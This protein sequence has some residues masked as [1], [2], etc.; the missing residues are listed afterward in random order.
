M[1]NDSINQTLSRTVL[2]S[3]HTLL[4]LLALFILGGKVLHG[5]AFALLAGIMT[6][7][8][9]EKLVLWRHSHDDHEC[10]VHKSTVTL[11]I[12]GD[13]V[14]TFVDGVVIAAAF[15]GVSWKLLHDI[16]RAP[17]AA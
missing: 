8:V 2:T 10:D 11:V 9:L 14:H 15:C 13:A 5:F 3:G 12:F 6:F 1:V 16:G 17:A 4:V 7:F